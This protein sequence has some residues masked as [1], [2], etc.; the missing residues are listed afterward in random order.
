MIVENFRNRIQ[1]SSEP[2]QI[3]FEPEW[4]WDF[5]GLKVSKLKTTRSTKPVFSSKNQILSDFTGIS[6]LRL[7]HG[8][9]NNFSFNYYRAYFYFANEL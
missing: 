2:D 3:G 9:K 1:S 7:I 5:W 6:G 8:T 4:T